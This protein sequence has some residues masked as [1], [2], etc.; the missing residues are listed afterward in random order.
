MAKGRRASTRRNIRRKR[1]P[2][3]VA[4]PFNAG[5]SLAGL[6]NDVV[7]VQGTL[8]AAFGEDIYIISVDAAWS[9]SGMVSGE[10]PINFG[11][12]HGDLSVTEVLETLDSEVTDPDDIIAR[13]RA[14]RPVRRVGTMPGFVTNEVLLNGTTVRTRVGFSVGD[15]HTLDFYAV[16]R[17]GSTISSAS[18]RLEIQGTI[19][20]RWQ[21]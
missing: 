7:V 19:F 21:R 15:G 3:F 6:V 11:F 12:S 10:G 18:Q 5:L 13:E 8:G 1:N 16:N 2:N 20:G 17:S 9:T 4:I 14:R